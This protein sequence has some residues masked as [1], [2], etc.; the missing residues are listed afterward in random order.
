M[1]GVHSGLT[2][3]IPVADMSALI[4]RLEAAYATGIMME[5][6][7]VA[8]QTALGLEDTYDTDWKRCCWN[9]LKGSLDAALAVLGEVLPA[10][11]WQLTR[12][13]D[14]MALACIQHSRRVSGPEVCAHTPALALVIAILRAKLDGYEAEG[15]VNQTRATGDRPEKGGAL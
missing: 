14:E 6:E 9:A 1:S 4:A 3:S 10:W 7:A 12:G 11:D 15:G 5:S 8:L 13:A 2:A